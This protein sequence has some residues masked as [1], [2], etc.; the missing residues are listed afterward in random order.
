MGIG[1]ILFFSSGRYTN[2]NTGNL[3]MTRYFQSVR[4]DSI[5]TEA[6]STAVPSVIIL[7]KI[8]E[9]CPYNRR[10]RNA[11]H[12]N[13]FFFLL[14][15]TEW[16]SHHSVEFLLRVVPAVGL[17]LKFLAVLYHD[18]VQQKDNAALR[19][20][21]ERQKTLPQPLPYRNRQPIRR[22]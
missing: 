7:L 4:S 9:T 6:I 12:R 14:V 18:L 11:S 1:N 16:I 22:A 15:L 21:L 8:P 3:S 17:V 19:K 13:R 5:I 10:E 20:K 2:S